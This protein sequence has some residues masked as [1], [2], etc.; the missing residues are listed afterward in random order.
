MFDVLFSFYDLETKIKSKWGHQLI[1]I[2]R[3]DSFANIMYL[4]DKKKNIK[5]TAT[6]F[7]LFNILHEKENLVS[8]T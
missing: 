6:I 8:D 7:G 4:K 5:M 3:W 2:T 1:D